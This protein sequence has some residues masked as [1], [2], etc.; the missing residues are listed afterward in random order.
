[1]S[2]NRRARPRSLAH[3]DLILISGG[4]YILMS[5][6]PELGCLSLGDGSHR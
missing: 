5:E 6:C 2:F 1:M 3:P 4:P